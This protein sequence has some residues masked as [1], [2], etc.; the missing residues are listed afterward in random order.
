MYDRERRRAAAAHENF[1]STV[2][3]RVV[4][5]MM[6]EPSTVPWY[7]AARDWRG[8]M[9]IAGHSF[10]G[11]SVVLELAFY[12][13]ASTPTNFERSRFLRKEICTKQFF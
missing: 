2:A 4:V 6:I 7:L 8:N 11:A 3:R 12:R 13:G 9:R 10:S 5:M 1:T